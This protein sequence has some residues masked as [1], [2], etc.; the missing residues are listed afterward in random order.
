MKKNHKGGFIIF[1]MAVICI[2]MIAFFSKS[3]Q[4]KGISINPY[5]IQ[6]EAEV[7]EDE[8]IKINNS[9]PYY[10]MRE[11]DLNHC[12]LGKPMVVSECSNFDKKRPED[13]IK[14]YYFGYSG[15]SDNSGKIIVRY[16]MYNEQDDSYIDFPS[17][18]GYV[19]SGYYI[20]KD[21]EEYRIYPSGVTKVVEEDTEATTEKKKGNGGGRILPNS[22]DNGKG[23]SSGTT[24]QKKDSTSATTEFDPDDHD[25]DSYYEDNKDEFDD[26]DDAYD[27]FE[28]DEDAWDD[29]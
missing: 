6:S 28:D 19:D 8:P 21:G 23:L 12:I 20:D 2:G 25:I 22:K 13:Q 11:E 9:Y 17:D 5:K 3:E 7:S 26:I 14:Y 4:K 10:G 24:K 1:I 16:R 15:Y 18:N 29:Y 27:A